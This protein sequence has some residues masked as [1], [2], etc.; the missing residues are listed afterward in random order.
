[1]VLKDK[2]SDSLLG[3]ESWN[4][5][6]KNEYVW[7][8]NIETNK[9]ST[10]KIEEIELWIKEGFE[11]GMYVSEEASKRRGESQLGEKNH[12]SH[13]CWVFKDN[14]DKIILKENLDTYLYDGWI[15]GRAP[16]RCWIFK[17]DINKTV[18]K[19]ELQ[20]YIIDGWKLG[21]K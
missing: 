4:K 10:V 13:K 1:M 14:E 2:I 16:K 11:V 7:V 17:N 19:L 3:N 6:N 15:R 18:N 5:G 8:H 9:N 21:R 20:T 12:M